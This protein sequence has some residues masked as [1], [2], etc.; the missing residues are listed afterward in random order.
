MKNLLKINLP[1]TTLNSVLTADDANEI[2]LLI[3]PLNSQLSG[4]VITGTLADGSSVTSGEIQPV[5]GEI[6]F[7][8]PFE[9][10]SAE[11]TLQ[12]Q[13]ESNEGNSD[14]IS[15]NVTSNLT[16]DDDIKIRLISGVFT[17]TVHT[18]SSDYDLLLQATETGTKTL[19][20]NIS[21]YTFIFLEGYFSTTN[22]NESRLIPRS[23]FELGHTY[24]LWSNFGGTQR[25]ISVKYESDTSVTIAD[26]SALNVRVYG[27]N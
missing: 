21:D 22:I 27:I 4:Y 1:D 17:V 25:E 10:Y 20:G 8:L 5:N 23:I 11:G 14:Y 13:L 26:R 9:W 6:Q 15:F 3:T 16:A 7:T 2:I 24:Y 19:D 12:L 18:D